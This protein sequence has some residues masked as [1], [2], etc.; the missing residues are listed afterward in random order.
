MGALSGST[1]GGVFHILSAVVMQGQ[2][3]MGTGQRQW[4]EH[5]QGTED[6]SRK[7]AVV[8]SWGKKRSETNGRKMEG[9]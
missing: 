8:E 6:H 9:K 1:R 4:A 5:W 3:G 7:E 2:I